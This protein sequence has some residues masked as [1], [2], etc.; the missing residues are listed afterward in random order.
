MQWFRYE[1]TTCP[2]CR[3]EGND[4]RWI[5]YTPGQRVAILKRRRQSLPTVVQQKL[6]RLDSCKRHLQT[7]KHEHKTL[8]KEYETLFRS[9]RYLGRRVDVLQAEHDRIFGELSVQASEHVPLLYP[10]DDDGS[11]DE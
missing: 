10:P 7:A 2:L 11:D 4:Q 9:E 6:S 5:Q 8:R 1:H 3:S